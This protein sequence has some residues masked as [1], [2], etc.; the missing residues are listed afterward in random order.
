MCPPFMQ[1]HDC[2]KCMSQFVALNVKIFTKTDILLDI[3]YAYIKKN[4]LEQMNLK[5]IF[6]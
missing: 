5:V 2:Y 4:N 1:S 3:I 6:R